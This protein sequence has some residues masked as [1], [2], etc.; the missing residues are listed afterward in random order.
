MTPGASAAPAAT[1]DR[2][3]PCVSPTRVVS[4]VCSNTE[5]VHAL[6]C[7]HLLVGVDDH[8]DWPPE[9]VGPLPRVGPE[10]GVDAERV[11]RLEPDL[12]L[13]SLSVPGHERVVDSLARRGLPCVVTDPVG[14]EDVFTDILHLAALLGVPSRGERLVGELRG[15]LSGLARPASGG[16]RVLVEWWPKPVIAP[17]RRSWVTQMIE[18]AGGENPLA[19]RDVRS[20]PLADSEVVALDPDAVVI[21]WCGVP[22]HRY[23]P[24]VVRR[25]PG[26][27][28]LRCVGPGRVHAISEEFLGRPGPRLVEGVRQLRVVVDACR[29][30]VDCGAP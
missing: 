5:I 24:E 2:R 1:T 15:E 27:R 7:S 14:L 3:A 22:F 16:P 30:A 9:V 23:R 28:G 13:A 26:W 21:A 12:V 17:G 4:T 18:L 6:G 29:A 20:L 19:E 8:S 25:R 10:L 11:A